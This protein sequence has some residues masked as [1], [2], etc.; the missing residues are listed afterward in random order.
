MGN[1]GFQGTV[2]SS[3]HESQASLMLNALFKVIDPMRWTQF[4]AEDALSPLAVNILSEGTNGI[5]ILCKSI[6]LL[7]PLSSRIMLLL[8]TPKTR[9][10][11][12]SPNRRH[13]PPAPARHLH[14]P[15]P[16]PYLLPPPNPQPQTYLPPPSLA[17][18]ILAALTLPLLAH[19]THPSRAHS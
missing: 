16:L 13:S 10:T 19:G 2:C 9:L 12:S 8:L 15:H 14:R 6:Y 4:T 7:P 3:T 17:Q 1:E 5:H 11:P 18:Q